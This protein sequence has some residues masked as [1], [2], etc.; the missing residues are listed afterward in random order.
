M[1]QQLERQIRAA[2]AQRAEEAPLSGAERLMSAS[3][4]PRT[5]R[6]RA[7]TVLVPLATLAGA[8]ITLALTGLGGGTSRALASW[9]ASPTSPA[10]G[11]AAAAEAACRAEMPSASQA[12]RANREASGSPDAEPGPALSPN[13]LPSVLSDTRGAY[14][15]LLLASGGDRA[16][17]LVGPWPSSQVLFA[18]RADGPAS[19]DTPG[20]DQIAGPAF[21]FGRLTGGEGVLSVTGHAGTDVRSVTL[22]LRDGTR[23][24][25][26]L[27]NGWFLAWWPGTDL[28]VS[29]EVQSPRGTTVVDL[30]NPLQPQQANLAKA[31]LGTRGVPPAVAA[32]RLPPTG[33]SGV[34]H[35]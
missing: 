20:A 32:R 18:S 11:Q 8:G 17:C 21:G 3:Y 22:T 25:T 24:V 26:R 31:A 30:K 5:G 9:N 13:A 35:R 23:V 29:A 15:Y 4:R 19:V 14:T 12:Q 2:L 28:A 7:T 33:Q 6:S 27:I 1:T 10:S 16:A 34:S